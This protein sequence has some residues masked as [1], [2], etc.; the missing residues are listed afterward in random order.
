MHLFLSD[1]EW[2]FVILLAIYLA[3][4][5]CWLRRKAVCFSLVARRHYPLRWPP[6]LGNVDAGLVFT[7][8][9]P[10]AT[11]W[12]CEPWPLAIGPEGVCLPRG[13]A[14]RFVAFEAVRSARGED[15]EVRS[16]GMCLAE[17]ASPEH[18]RRLAATLAEIAGAA[19]GDRPQLVEDKLRASTDLDAVAARVAELR[20][21]GRPLRAAS[22]VFFVYVFGLGPLLYYGPFSSWRV[23]WSYL[24]CLPVFWL[25]TIA[26]YLAC[27]RALLEE[28]RGRRWQHAAMLVLSPGAAMRAAESLFRPGLAEFHP[29]AVAAALSSRRATMAMAKAALLELDNPLPSDLP[30]D[31]AARRVDW[32]FRER[33]LENF[34]RALGRIAIDAAALA[35]PP[36]PLEDARSFCPRC[37][38]QF[39][40]PAGTCRD[41]G[42]MPLKPL[43]LGRGR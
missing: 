35:A 25:L 42:G 8:P 7:N 34:R 18:A 40:A 6:F 41:C 12:V 31:P 33:L 5:A 43:P 29:L 19:P 14:S 11:A 30:D 13:P 27:R 3:E 21:L 36:A 37:H 10:W 4:C 39:V 38:N 15:R 32:W 1:V 28:P 9:L 17:T 16:D 23:V 22:V 24:A 2:L 26:E 20:K